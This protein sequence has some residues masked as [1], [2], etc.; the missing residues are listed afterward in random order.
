ML[1]TAGSSLV[2]LAAR[3]I[4]LARSMNSSI[5][6]WIP[7]PSVASGPRRQ[8]ISSARP[9]E[10]RLVVTMPTPRQRCRIASTI[11]PTSSRRCSQLSKMTSAARS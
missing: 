5:A 1:A 9:N 8:T 7:S 6:D 2:T 11:E 4:A 10:T 3:V